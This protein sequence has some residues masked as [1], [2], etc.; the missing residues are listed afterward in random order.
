VVEIV[1]RN[2]LHKFVALPKR[3]PWRSV[4]LEITA[5]RRLRA[6]QAR[7]R[8]TARRARRLRAEDL[9]AAKI[10]GK[11]SIKFYF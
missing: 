11:N 8:S 4:S 5:K 10:V 9:E 7:V 6:I 1:K 3:K 2:E